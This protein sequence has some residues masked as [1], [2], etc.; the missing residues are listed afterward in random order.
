MVSRL[1]TFAGSKQPGCRR[2]Q[3]PPSRTGRCAGWWP[4]RRAARRM[5][6]PGCSAMRSRSAP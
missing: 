5:R 6:W 2:R 3:G 4:M 1:G